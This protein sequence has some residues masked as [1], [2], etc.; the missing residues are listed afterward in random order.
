M[1]EGCSQS[2]DQNDWQGRGKQNQ[3]TKVVRRAE[4]NWI[5]IEAWRKKGHVVEEE[6]DENTHRDDMVEQ[7]SVYMWFTVTIVSEHPHPFSCPVPPESFKT[8]RAVC[9]TA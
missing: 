6:S 8:Y 9:A 2:R 4:N 1:T 7:V 5:I 3:T